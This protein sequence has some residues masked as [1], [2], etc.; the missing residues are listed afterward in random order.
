MCVAINIVSK[1]E[2]QDQQGD[3]IVHFWV[4]KGD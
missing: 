2:L 3:V 1:N 4:R